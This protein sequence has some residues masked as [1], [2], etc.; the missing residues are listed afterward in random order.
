[1]ATVANNNAK[2]T[3]RGGGAVGG[4]GAS[5][6]SGPIT[7]RGRA[8]SGSRAGSLSTS[9]M[10]ET[11]PSSRSQYEPARPTGTLLLMMWVCQ[12][13]VKRGGDIKRGHVTSP[14]LYAFG[15]PNPLPCRLTSG[16]A[17]WLDCAPTGHA[18]LDQHPECG[19][20]AAADA[21]RFGCRF[22]AAAAQAHAKQGGWADRSGDREWGQ[23][24]KRGGMSS[25]FRG[26]KFVDVDR[27]VVC[28]VP[29]L[30]LCLTCCLLIFCFVG[31]HRL[32]RRRAHRFGPRYLGQRKTRRHPPTAR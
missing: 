32:A 28:L 13:V 21:P 10:G 25:C 8:G 11:L 1:M 9:P 3:I 6:G 26:E 15:E 20:H 12:R 14:F 31:Y 5:G 29:A 4:A 18:R 17:V 27:H 22:A 16:V 2:R 7:I 19:G 24:R 23:T 30:I